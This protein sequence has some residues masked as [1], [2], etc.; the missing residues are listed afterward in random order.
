[1]VACGCGVR[2]LRCWL[3]R[4]GFGLMLWVVGRMVLGL[5]LVLLAA[6][7]CRL[8][9]VTW[10]VDF[11]GWGSS[12]VLCRYVFGILCGLSGFGFGLV[13]SGSAVFVWWVWWW[14][15]GVCWVGW[16]CGFGV[17]VSGCVL[18]GVVGVFVVCRFCGFGGLTFE[19]VGGFYFGVC[20]I[21]FWVFELGCVLL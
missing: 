12:V 15:Y 1:M 16:F 7:G 18:V 19:F 9:L 8:L 11:A 14:V 17:L 10:L 5:G 21:V 20:G 2:S 4:V 13:V 3:A 6:G